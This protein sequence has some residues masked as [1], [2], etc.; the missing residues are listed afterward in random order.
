MNDYEGLNLP[1][2][3]ALMHEIVL[4]D[5]ISRVPEGAG[6]WILFTWLLA[7]SVIFARH[8]LLRRKANA[9]RR[10]AIV[11]LR[12]IASDN[13]LSASETAEQIAI[14]VKRTAL[15]AYPRETVA[16][17]YGADWAQFLRETAS[18]DPVVS[19]AADELAQAAYRGDTDGKDLVTPARRWIR[20]HRA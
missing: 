1:D 4:P 2:L 18:N 15:A 17:L 11:L 3:L 19:N 20:V 10:D 12:H 13:S 6:W 9:Y 8:L 14:L 7:C 16:S 5:A